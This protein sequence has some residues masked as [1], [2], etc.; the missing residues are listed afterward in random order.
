MKSQLE[1]PD[2]IIK[3][4]EQAANQSGTTVVEWISVRLPNPHGNGKAVPTAAE[5]VA[6]NAR[7]E[8]CIAD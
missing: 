6:A 1:L 3:A 4:L 7:L 2:T 8:A 5:I